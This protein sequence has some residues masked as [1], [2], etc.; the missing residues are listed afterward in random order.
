M[1]HSSLRE[2]YAHT[3]ARARAEWQSK[4]TG[5]SACYKVGGPP[6]I[7][8]IKYIL[9]TFW[10]CKQSLITPAASFLNSSVGI[11]TSELGADSY[12]T[13]SVFIMC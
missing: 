10:E 6:R 2:A 5:E 1:P 11:K 12:V 9:G 13:D 8:K 4:A 3:R 7:N